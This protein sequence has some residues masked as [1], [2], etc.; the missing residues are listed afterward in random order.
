MTHCIYSVE[1]GFLTFWL[2]I[3]FAVGLLC[4]HCATTV[5]VFELCLSLPPSS[6]CLTLSR[7][8]VIHCF[9]SESRICCTILHFVTLFHRF[10]TVPPHSLRLYARWL[11]LNCTFR[12]STCTL[13][14]CIYCD[15][16]LCIYSTFT[17]LTVLGLLYTVY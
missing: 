16:L 14:H 6:K 17:V 10:L 9:D 1:P 2:G 7:R 5:R 8:A 15:S 3:L 13:S 11:D 12:H 4:D